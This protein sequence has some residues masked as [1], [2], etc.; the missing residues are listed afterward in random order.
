MTVI[1]GLRSSREN[2]S[3][4]SKERRQP[5]G[6]GFGDAWTVPWPSSRSISLVVVLPKELKSMV[7]AAPGHSALARPRKAWINPKSPEGRVPSFPS[8]ARLQGECPVGQGQPPAP[9]PVSGERLLTPS[10]LQVSSV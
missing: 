7:P 5:Q 1:L 10:T 2:L 4:S 6:P 3:H 8:L 9:C